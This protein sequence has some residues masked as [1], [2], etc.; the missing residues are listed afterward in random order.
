MPT[1]DEVLFCTSKTT[2]EEVE[3]FLRLVL[4]T[5]ENESC[6]Y[7]VANVQELAYEA[8][9]TLEQ[10]LHYDERFNKPLQV[11]G[12][13]ALVFVSTTAKQSLIASVLAKYRVNPVEFDDDMLRVYINDKLQGDN[14][15]AVS[16]SDLDPDRATVRVLTSK[17][18]G[19]GK[20]KYVK[21]LM[22]KRSEVD[23]MTVRVKSPVIDVDAEIL[24]FINCQS[25]CPSR[26]SARIYHVDIAYEV[27]G[28]F[29]F[30][31]SLLE[32]KLARFESIKL[33][34]Y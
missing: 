14:K 3:S 16:V 4:T 18:S 24:K 21:H 20:S 2:G 12:R 8:Q 13:F 10:Y 11:R 27:G 31:I 29:F 32:L 25:K 34:I 28:I 23:K 5:R 7:C 19:N 26:Y 1:N 15:S 22:A 6:L 30:F 33:A 9:T 17:R